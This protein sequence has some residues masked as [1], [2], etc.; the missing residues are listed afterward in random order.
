MGGQAQQNFPVCFTD[1][2]LEA[3]EAREDKEA[4]WRSLGTCGGVS[5]R[6]GVQE[7]S[8]TGLLSPASLS[9]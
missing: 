4:L 3:Q 5:G 9:H 6:E 1:E 2:Q 7:P 8:V